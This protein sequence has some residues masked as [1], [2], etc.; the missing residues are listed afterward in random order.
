MRIPHT[1]NRNVYA[2]Y[3]ASEEA[4]NLEFEKK[5]KLKA[6]NARWDETQLPP[7]TELCIGVIVENFHRRQILS[8]LPCNDKNLLL[9]TL[10]TDL[11]LPLV[12]KYLEDGVYW[13]RKVLDR[14]RDRA[15]DVQDYGFSWKRMYMEKHVQEVVESTTPEGKKPWK[16]KKKKKKSGPNFFFS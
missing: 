8:G 14:W 12:T 5:R 7:L 1:I 16:M 6:E 2:E 9:E 4:T 10:P 11:P 15:I 3:E 13:K